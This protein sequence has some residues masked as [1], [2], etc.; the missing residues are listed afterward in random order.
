MKVI[1]NFRLGID[2]NMAPEHIGKVIAVDHFGRDSARSLLV[3]LATH[4][5]RLAGFL[6]RRGRFI[7]A[8]L[9]DAKDLDNSSFPDFHTTLLFEDGHR[10][11]IREWE[12]A[13]ITI[14]DDGK[15]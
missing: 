11:Q 4:F 13:T 1:G 9:A 12:R 8:D 3:E 5:G 7:A 10:V 15:D 2:D 6:E 14:Y